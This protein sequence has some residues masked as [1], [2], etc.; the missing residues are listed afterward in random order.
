MWRFLLLVV[1]SGCVQPERGVCLDWDIKEEI[2]DECTPLYGQM[3]CAERTVHTY[4]CVLREEL[5]DEPLREHP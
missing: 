2:R 3:I 1:L 5:K 4:Q